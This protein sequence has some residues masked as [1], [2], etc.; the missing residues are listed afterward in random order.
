VVTVNSDDPPM[1][2]TTLTDEYRFLA[3]HHGYGAN[4]LERLSL[5]AVRAAFLPDTEKARLLAEFQA[6]FSALRRQLGLA[7]AGGVEGC[8]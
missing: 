6:E 4:D 2:G 3:R 5:N 7:A 1:F 8:G